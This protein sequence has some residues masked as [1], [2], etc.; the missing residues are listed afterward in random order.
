[1]DYLCHIIKPVIM[2]SIFFIMWLLNNS[3]TTATPPPPFTI[4]HQS[5]GMKYGKTAD[6]QLVTV[7]ADGLIVVGYVTYQVK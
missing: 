4:T 7:F 1:M 2:K 5:G 6:G 3:L